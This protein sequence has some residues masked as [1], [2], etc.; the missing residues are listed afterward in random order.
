M[1]VDSHVHVWDITTRDHGWT[2]A[3]HPKLV[4]SFLPEQLAA[5]TAANGIDAVV[6]VQVLHS[7]EE[8]EEFLRLSASGA[9][10]TK[11]SAVVGWVD[12]EAPDAGEQIAALR[13]GPGGSRLAGIRHLLQ[14]GSADWLG[15]PTVQRGLAAVRDAGLCYDLLVRCWQIADAQRAL[16]TVEGL[17]IVLDHG[18]KPPIRSGELDPWRA[19]VARLAENPLVSCK[20]SG[21]VTE[22][23]EDWTAE[24]IRPYAEHLLDCF[25][26][27]RCLAGTDWPVSTAMATYEQV[28]ALTRSLLDGLTAA[29]RDG[30]LDANARRVYGLPAGPSAP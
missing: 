29:E 6:L 23:G 9:F 19:D 28:W 1:T 27:G 15:L 13:E 2:A 8:T 7:I 24:Q 20:I 25:G 5:L 21:L 14:A 10:G 16:R 3:E 11:T 17:S 26:P 4:R 12:L 22:A 30:A 18:G